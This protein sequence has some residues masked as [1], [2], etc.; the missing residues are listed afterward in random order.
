MC[1]IIAYTFDADVHCPNCT[2][3]AAA[4]GTLTRVPPLSLETDE[5][6]I[7]VDLIDSEGNAVHPVFDNVD[8]PE[9][10]HCGCCGCEIVE[11]EPEPEPEP[12]LCMDTLLD[13][14]MEC[15]LWS[16]SDLSVPEPSDRSLQDR[17]FGIR[18]F[19]ATTAQ[20]MYEDCEAFVRENWAHIEQVLGYDT[21]DETNIGHDLWLSRNG[22][23]AGFFDRVSSGHPLRDA[24]DA[25]QDAARALG[26]V[27]LCTNG[28]KV[29]SC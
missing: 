7:A 26:E 3:E 14:Y 19:A 25:L 21:Y 27:H 22:H 6:G 17:G 10:M 11:P 12:T 18:D 20:E 4:N 8:A 23:G 15:A 29:E 1:S 2:A 24:F 13:A 5:N 9:G 28:T 16:S